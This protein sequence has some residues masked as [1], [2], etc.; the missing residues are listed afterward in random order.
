M[1]LCPLVHSFQSFSS[2]P[3]FLSLSLSPS[4]FPSPSDSNGGVFNDISKRPENSFTDQL[5]GYTV[6]SSAQHITVS[7]FDDRGNWL[8]VTA[9]LDLL[10]FIRMQ[11]YTSTG[12]S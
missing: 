1:T 4:L 8:A 11:K 9:L 3:L 6:E 5:L 12:A 2:L 7:N 10:N